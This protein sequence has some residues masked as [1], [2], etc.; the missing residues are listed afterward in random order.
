MGG[1]ELGSVKGASVAIQA[2]DGYTLITAITNTDGY[3]SVDIDELKTAVNRYGSDLKY[4]KV[5]STGGIDTDPNDDGVL[6]E[7]EQIN[8]Q[9]N[10]TGIVP[11]KTLYQAKD[12]RINFMSTAL[13]DILGED[14]DITD[15]K[16]QYTFIGQVDIICDKVYMLF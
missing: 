5:I 7:S 11:L 8:I 15:E 3:F 1:I 14:T 2:L 12:Y 4:V 9:G 16:L 10:V 6:I 13:V